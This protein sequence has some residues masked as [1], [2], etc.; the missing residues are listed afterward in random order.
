MKKP[1]TRPVPFLAIRRD[2]SQQII[3]SKMYP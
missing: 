1:N 3:A 2:K